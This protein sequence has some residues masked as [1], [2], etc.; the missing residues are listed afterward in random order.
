MASLV[1][2]SPAPREA[3]ASS[4]ALV[5]ALACLFSGGCVAQQ[6]YDGKLRPLSAVS[7][8][9]PKGTRLRKVDGRHAGQGSSFAILP[10]LHAVTVTLDDRRAPQSEHRVSDEYM[11]ACIDALPGHTYE[12]SPT[13]VGVGG[14][15]W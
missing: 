9:A 10:G 3:R 5:I 12:V 1:A 4:T 15:G 14:E 13:Y 7:V 8:I 2:A 6:L 11:A